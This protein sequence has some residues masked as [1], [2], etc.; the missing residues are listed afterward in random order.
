MAGVVESAG[1]STPL[2]LTGAGVIARSVLLLFLGWLYGG[3]LI[4]WVQAQT[5]EVTAMSELPRLWLSLLG[6]A[7]TIGG[8]VVLVMARKQPPS[9]RPVRLLTIAAMGLL[10]V[11]FVVLNSR[12]SPLSTDEQTLLAA[13][14]IAES[15]NHEAG[16]EAVPRDPALLH[17]FL[18]GLGTVPFFVKGERV[19]GWKLEL[20]ERCAGPA[21]D[22]GEAEVGTVIYCVAADRK[23]AWVTLVGTPLGQVF[24]PRAIVSTREGWV[25]D[26][27][28]AAEPEQEDPSDRPVWEAPTPNQP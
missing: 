9:W 16:S 23:R 19:P 22:P 17:S 14:Y 28:V 2:G 11:D 1:P 27:H 25:G 20:R 6:C 7:V 21:A 24:G 8:V 10:F 13:Q 4:R 18:Q 26:V 12:R 3:D 15:A 5:A